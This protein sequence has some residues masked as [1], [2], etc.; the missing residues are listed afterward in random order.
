MYIKISNTAREINGL[1]LKGESVV[2]IDVLRAT[3]TMINALYHG[4]EKITTF[5]DIEEARAYKK[6]FPNTVLGGERNALKPKDFD[7]GNSP[8]EYTNFAGRE[9]ALTTTNGT[10]ALNNAKKADKI[11][12]MSFHNIEATCTYLK[13][14]KSNIRFICAGTEGEFSLDDALCAVEA[15]NILKEDYE[16]DDMSILLSKSIKDKNQLLKDA[17]HYNTLMV[18]GF[19][20][21][22]DFALKTYNHNFIAVVDNCYIIRK[23]M[24]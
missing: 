8:L 3:T 13:S 4:I 5:S 14:K 17:K 12:I 1:D 9:L 23:N 11:L 16:I 2:V 18:K 19:N 7:C 24:T 10:L 21:D 22:V 6:K 20:N 15:V